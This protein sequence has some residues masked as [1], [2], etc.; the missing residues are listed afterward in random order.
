[1]SEVV[2]GEVRSRLPRIAGRYHSPSHLAARSEVE[3]KNSPR[4]NHVLLFLSRGNLSPATVTPE[5]TGRAIIAQS[6]FTHQ[7]F[8]PGFDLVVPPVLGPPGGDVW[9]ECAPQL[10]ARR[11]YLLTF[12]GHQPTTSII[13]HGFNDVF[14]DEEIHHSNQEDSDT[15]DLPR[16]PALPRAAG[17]ATRVPPLPRASGTCTATRVPPVWSRQR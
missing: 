7:L 8:R 2:V 16:D 15:D 4:R 17:T 12:Q 6:S 13:S 3:K 1:M 11:K 5:L 14:I 9:G 10:P